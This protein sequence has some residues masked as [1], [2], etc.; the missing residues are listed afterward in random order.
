VEV[1]ELIRHHALAPR[2]AGISFVSERR[3]ARVPECNPAFKRFVHKKGLAY[4][5]PPVESYE[6][7]TVAL[8]EF[9]KRFALLLSSHQQGRPQPFA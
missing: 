9:L 8:V 6:F 3:E 7:G 5:S 4:P 2:V 1:P